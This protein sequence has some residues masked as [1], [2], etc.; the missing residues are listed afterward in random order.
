MLGAVGVGGGV[1]GEDREVKQ[2]CYLL[3]CGGGSERAIRERVGAAWG[4]G[5]E[6]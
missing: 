5:K 1:V 2:F 6:I 4:K 3:G